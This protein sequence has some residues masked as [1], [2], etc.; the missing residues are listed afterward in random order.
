MA[1]LNILLA[2]TSKLKKYNKIIISKITPKE[3]RTYIRITLLRKKRWFW[4]DLHSFCGFTYQ[5][6][7]IP[8]SFNPSF[9]TT[10]SR[11]VILP[12][13]A[14]DRQT[15]Q[16]IDVRGS[17]KGIVAFAISLTAALENN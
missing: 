10:G 16:I 12:Y 14:D 2:F 6:L 5:I 17:T 1:E 13:F 9:L 4:K 15:T 8:I 3:K 11:I 7:P